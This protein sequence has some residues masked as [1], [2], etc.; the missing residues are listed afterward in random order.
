MSEKG[1]PL[2]QRKMQT[3]R[4]ALLPSISETFGL[5]IL[6]AWAAGTPAISSRTSGASA[7]IAEDKT[8]WLF[9]L[10][11]PE[12]FHAA[13]DRVLADHGAVEMITAAARARVIADYDTRVL[14]ARLHELYATLTE[15]RHA[16][17]YSA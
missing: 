10:G 9:D 4:V 13:V 5:V 2:S 15:E 8:G 6:E 3:A 1:S 12:A 7:L 14:A 16:H 11:K 17:R